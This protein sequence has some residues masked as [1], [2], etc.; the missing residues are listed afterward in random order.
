MSFTSKNHTQSR[1]ILALL[2]LFSLLLLSACQ[3]EPAGPTPAAPPPPAA[4]TLAA[5]TMELMPTERPATTAEPP[6]AEEALTATPRSLAG[7][8]PAPEFP[9]GMEWFNVPEPLTL[10]QLKGKIVLLDFWT[11]GCI[12]CIHVIPELKQL[13]EKYANELVVVGIHSAKF[14]NEAEGGK[15]QPHHR[16]L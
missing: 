7:T 5:A 2:L 13:E 10:A 14:P 12:N 11:Y 6:V 8:V 3:D 16:A 9:D 1:F 4:S 15:H